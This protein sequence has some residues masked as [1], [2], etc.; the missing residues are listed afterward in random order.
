MLPP[1]PHEEERFEQLLGNV[2]RT[3]V[4]FAASVV[5]V[6]GVLFLMRHGHEPIDHKTFLGEPA[7]LRHPTEIVRRV[8]RFDERG[9][10]MLGLLLLVA[11][12][13]VRVAFSV[14]GFARE[15]DFLYVALTLIVFG[16]LLYSLFSGS[17]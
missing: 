17:A 8:L 13:V 4:L 5:L 15:R 3:G 7:D 6:G 16:T 1:D 9:I 12:P 2:L 14:F 10:I 11:T